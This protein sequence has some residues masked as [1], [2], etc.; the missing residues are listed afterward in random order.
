VHGYL[1]V[2]D[3][4]EKQEAALLAAG[5]R[6][7]T[8]DRRGSGKSS[9]PSTG[10]DYDTL[11]ADLG[12]LLDH[13]DLRGVTL[14]GFG[15]GTG[16][17]VRY[18]A[19]R[20]PRRI[21]RAALLAPLPPFLPRAPGNPRGIDPRAFDKFTRD[22]LAD[23]P[24]AVKAF[25]DSCYNLDRFGGARVSDHAWQNAFYTAVGTA[26]PAAVGCV[27]A[28]Q[29][30]FRAG[31]T[32]HRPGPSNAGQRRP[33]AAAWGDRQPAGCRHCSAMSATS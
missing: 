19:L 1:A 23:R 3:S 5:Y 8:Y 24:A 20:G 27:A 10:Y 9:R 14:A 13:L 22:L 4:W 11:A 17:V 12:A 26:L 2:G 33:G 7:I 6:V 15:M 30:E 31:L 28:G 29:E 18:L 25:V 32:D 21:S 16:V